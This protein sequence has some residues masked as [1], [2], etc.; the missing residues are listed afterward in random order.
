MNRVRYERA[1][2]RAETLA[3]WVLRL[4]GYKVLER[5]F[6]CHKGEIDIIAKKRRSLVIVEVKQRANMIAAEDSLTPSLMYRVSEAADVYVSR[7]P[8]AQKL[9]LRFD[10]VFIIGRWKVCHLKD[11]W[12]F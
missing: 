12:R 1:G 2:R 8:Y 10:A 6:K 9:G 3:V 11:V 5:R 7:N 4:K